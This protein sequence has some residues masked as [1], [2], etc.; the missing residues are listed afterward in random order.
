METKVKTYQE[1]V[2][3]LKNHY[4]PKPNEIVQM[5]K[6][7]SCTRKPEEFV[8]E[9]VAELS[10]SLARLQLW[11]QVT[12]NAEDTSPWHFRKHKLGQI[13]DM[14]ARRVDPYV[15]KLFVNKQSVQ[16]EID[17]GAV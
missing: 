10:R 4:H 9:Y 1:L 16:F 17:T 5:Y 8:L 6:F 14:H 15:V 11:R 7:D 13:S 3:L 2:Q 12:A